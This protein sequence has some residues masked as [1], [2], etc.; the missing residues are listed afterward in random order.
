MIRKVRLS[1][2]TKIAGPI[3]DYG[4]L[5]KRVVNLEWIFEEYPEYFENTR[6]TKDNIILEINQGLFIEDG[7]LGSESINITKKRSLIISPKVLKLVKEKLF[8]LN[9]NI[10]FNIELYHGDIKTRF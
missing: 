3:N 2:F 4:L 5:S 6:G 10:E 7:E 1:I 9:K 8:E